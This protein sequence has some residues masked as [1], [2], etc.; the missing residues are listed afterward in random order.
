MCIYIYLKA[1]MCYNIHIW[2]APTIFAVLNIIVNAFV[3]TTLL[4]LLFNDIIIYFS[5]FATYFL[6]PS[7]NQNTHT[8]LSN[9]L[10]PQTI[11]RMRPVAQ[12]FTHNKYDSLP[13]PES[14]IGGLYSIYMH[15]KSLKCFVLVT[16]I[17]FHCLRLQ[18]RHQYSMQNTKFYLTVP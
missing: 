3:Y 17:L 8:R 16:M 7:T 11:H 10:T 9:I 18:Y 2:V 12:S 15:N 13:V 4:G 5:I 6:Y 14:E 1:H